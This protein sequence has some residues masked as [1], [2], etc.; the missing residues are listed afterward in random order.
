MKAILL[1]TAACLVFTPALAQTGASGSEPQLGAGT[2][3]SATQAPNIKFIQRRDTNMIG[4]TAMLGQ[5]VHGS[6]N[7]EV[8]QI[9]EL[10]FDQSGQIQGVVL[11][12][13][14]FS[15]D[16]NDNAQ[17]RYIAVPLSALRVEER[18]QTQSDPQTQSTTG[19]QSEVS[20]AAGGENKSRVNSRA[21]GAGGEAAAQG[22]VNTATGDIAET[23]ARSAR[24]ANRTADAA[25]GSSPGAHAGSQVA[26]DDSAPDYI[27]PSPYRISVQATREQLMAAPE[28]QEEIEPAGR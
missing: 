6:N 14:A 22:A 15:A 19:R 27:P 9:W 3:S 8:A 21:T 12:V 11:E 20:G 25:T 4:A 26:N 16:N 7:E 13:G 28:F 23:A 17:E 5:Y 18:A 2:K 1:T 24:E 10:L